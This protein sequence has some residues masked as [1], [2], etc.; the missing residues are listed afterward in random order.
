MLSEVYQKERHN[1]RMI[2]LYV[3]P[4]QTYT[5]RQTT[6]VHKGNKTVELSHITEL[7]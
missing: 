7:G 3:G 1:Y 6:K 2:S 4:I 5:T